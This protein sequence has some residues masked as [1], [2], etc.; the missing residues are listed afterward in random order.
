MKIYEYK[1]GKVTK[2]TFKEYLQNGN[3]NYRI[4]KDLHFLFVAISIVFILLSIVIAFSVI[5]VILYS[6]S[7]FL[8]IFIDTVAVLSSFSIIFHL[9]SIHKKDLSE[10]KSG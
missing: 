3:V 10:L 2:R 6:G 7:V 5:S 8:S 9:W 4:L 1:K